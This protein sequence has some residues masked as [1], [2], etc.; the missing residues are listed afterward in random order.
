MISRLREKR[1]WRTIMWNRIFI[2]ASLLL[3]SFL[4][5][6]LFGV[7]PLLLFISTLITGTLVWYSRRVVGEFNELKEDLNDLISKFDGFQQHLGEIQQMEMFYGDETLGSLMDHSRFL[8]ETI[9]YYEEKYYD[10][11]IEQYEE[12]KE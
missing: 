8:V 12:E 6:W 9:E 5:A 7:L 3:N 4:L 10:S 1:E 2:I 11:P